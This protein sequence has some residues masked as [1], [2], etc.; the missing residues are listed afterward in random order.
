MRVSEYFPYAFATYENDKIDVIEQAYFESDYQEYEEAELEKQIAKVK[1][2]EKPVET[3]I[4]AED[5][6][7][8]MSELMKILETRLLDITE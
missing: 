7:R 3:A 5:E 1:A 6:T 8:P 4:N 2:A